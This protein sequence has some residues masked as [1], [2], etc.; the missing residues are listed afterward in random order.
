MVGKMDA[1]NRPSEDD[2]E[3][4]VPEMEGFL[5]NNNT[6][7]L[8]NRQPHGAHN[9]LPNDGNNERKPPSVQDPVFEWKAEILCSSF[10]IISLIGTNPRLNAPLICVLMCTYSYDCRVGIDR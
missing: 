7:V 2:S 1:R 8:H 6:Q 3:Q 5:P 9:A 10:G 4:V